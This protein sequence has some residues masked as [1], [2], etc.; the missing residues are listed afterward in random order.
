[1]GLPQAAARRNGL[2]DAT[3]F[4]GSG[5]GKP[6]V[7]EEIRLRPWSRRPKATARNKRSN[8]TFAARP[9]AC[10]S[11]DNMT[12]ALIIPS[13]SAMKP[14]VASGRADRISG[15]IPSA[16]YL[17]LI[18]LL[19]GCYSAVIPLLVPLLFRC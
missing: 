4:A 15:E 7:L 1:V 14:S 2:A 11:A 17:D 16:K 10:S 18:P 12:L 19:F 5:H 3:S 6:I 8:P 13:S 9:V